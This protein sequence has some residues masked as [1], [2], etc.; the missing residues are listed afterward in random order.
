VHA[1]QGLGDTLQFI[2]YIPQLTKLGAQVV[3]EVQ[4]PLARLIAPTASKWGVQL[5]TRGEPR[6]AIDCECPLLSLPLALGT[7][8]ASIPAGLPYLSAPVQ[9]TLSTPAP[10]R[11]TVDAASST[12]TPEAFPATMPS[13]L[14]AASPTGDQANRRRRIGLAISGAIRERRETRAIA[15]S[16]L[17]P[18]FEIEGIDWVVLQTEMRAKDRAVLSAFDSVSFPAAA[19]QDFADTADTVAQLDLVL[20]ID[21]SLAHLA[22]AMRHPVWIMLPR[23]PDWRWGA[24]GPATPWYPS[25]RL[26]RQAEASDWTNV[27]AEVGAAL[28]QM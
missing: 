8:P 17:A 14:A 18:L 23:G 3:L 13:G 7:T 15:A 9:A 27:V 1:E 6:P 5:L 24:E 28:R 2:R 20:T 25:A 22:G 21:T 16:T 19:P 26:F 4:A 12:V 11:R 10:T